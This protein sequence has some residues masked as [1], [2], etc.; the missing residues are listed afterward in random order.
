M[1]GASTPS[2]YR[3]KA[4]IKNFGGCWAFSKLK[5]A[6]HTHQQQQQQGCEGVSLMTMQKQTEDHFKRPKQSG[7]EK[8]VI[9][10]GVFSL[11]ELL[12][13]LNL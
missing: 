13:S 11:E 7:P 2:K 12:E 8:G 1:F 5:A 4:Y 6:K 10:K 3:K 9:T